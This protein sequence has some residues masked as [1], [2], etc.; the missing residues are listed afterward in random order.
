MTL[1]RPALIRPVIVFVTLALGV[2]FA[3]SFLFPVGE[4]YGELNKPFFNPPNWVFGPVWTV[5][6][7]MIGFAGALAW[8]R[9]PKS[10]AVRVWFAQLILN[11]A[12]TAVFFGAKQIELAL[13]VIMILLLLIL[14]FT[15]ETRKEVPL[16]SWLFVPYL[17]W[18]SFAAMLNAAISSLN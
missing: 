8:R 17:L 6:Y 16:A 14:S 18:V 13:A 15:G 9:N 11:G 4:W 5:L 10:G 2:G 7:I 1:A 3:M 12:W